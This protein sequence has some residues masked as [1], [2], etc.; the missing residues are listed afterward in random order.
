LGALFISLFSSFLNFF[1][2]PEDR[3]IRFQ[4]TRHQ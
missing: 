1:I 4:V 2:F 3:K